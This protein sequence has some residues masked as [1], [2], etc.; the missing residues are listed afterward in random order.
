M[1]GSRN[2]DFA[3]EQ[4]ARNLV[5]SATHAGLTIYSGGA[6]GIDEIAA[7]EA[8]Q[9]GGHTVAFLA[10]SLVRSVRKKEVREA[11]S[12]GC[13][14]LISAVLPHTTFRSYNAMARN[15]Y[16]Y[17]L[18]Q[19][20]CVIAAD[21]G[22][23]GTWNGAEESLKHHYVPVFVWDTDKYPGNHAL[24]DLGAKAIPE[25]MPCVKKP[26]ITLRGVRLFCVISC[27]RGP[28]RLGV[29]RRGPWDRRFRLRG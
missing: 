27:L 24:L 13:M 6:R 7:R 11:V 22:K 21:A 25:T 19:A 26:Y 9:S 5:R 29:C 10:D 16:V 1:V 23:G 18:S 12:Q 15:K 20:A 14:L 28:F 3:G 2:I 8:L 17:A 4:Y